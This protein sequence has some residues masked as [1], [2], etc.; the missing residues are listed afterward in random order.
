MSNIAQIRSKINLKSTNKDSSANL[1]S[2][3]SSDQSSDMSA[4][5]S[6]KVYFSE[7]FDDAL[8]R[9]LFIKHDEG[10][11]GGVG[12]FTFSLA[13]GL[14]YFNSIVAYPYL[15]SL[16][17]DFYCK[18]KFIKRFLLN[19]THDYTKEAI[20]L[21]LIDYFKISLVN[22]QQLIGFKLKLLEDIKQ[23]NVPIVFNF[24]DLFFATKCRSCINRL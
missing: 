17:L 10:G 16:V 18:G 15:D 5:T 19:I 7:I 3:L 11:I 4:D 21:D 6:S 9:I 8:P 20:I 14:V 2:D 12:T 24:N 23:K 22:V 13:R 1:S